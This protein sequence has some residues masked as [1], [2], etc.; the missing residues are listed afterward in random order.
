LYAQRGLPVHLIC[1]TRGE[2][3]IVDPEYMEGFESVAALR[4]HELRCAAGKLGLA[5]VH[6]LDYRDSGMPG[7]EDNH[8][9]KAL[10]AAPVDEVAAQI[11]RYMRQLKP[12]VV[13]TFDP[14]GG[15]HHPD[16]IAIHNATVRA[17]ELADDNSFPTN[18]LPA[19]RPG[20]LYYHIMPRGYLRWLVRLM[21]LLGRDP[22]RY[23]RNEDID[24]VALSKDDFPVHAVIDYKS[25]KELKE[26]A[27]ACHASQGGTGAS[28]GLMG[29]IR[30]L[31]GDKDHFMRAYP[32]PNG[33][34]RAKDLFEGLDHVSSR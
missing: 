3:G 28:G 7:S 10:A 30:R 27:S 19:Y 33:R 2:V 14:I 6:F 13:L 5:G 26:Q 29:W 1:A 18:G 12:Q 22:H 20:G 11:A 31:R 25:V 32:P 8:H 21:P 16:H 17:F 9:P 24:L 15:Y 4:E 23:G 34:R